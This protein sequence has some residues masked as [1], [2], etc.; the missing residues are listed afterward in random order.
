MPTS[1]THA[2]SRSKIAGDA[3]YPDDPDGVIA[4]GFIAAGP[5]DESS[6]I[7]IMDDTVDTEIARYLDR[8]DM[9]A[10]TMSTFA[11]STVHCARCHDHKSDPIS[12]GE[13]HLLHAVFAGVK[14][15]NRHY[16]PDPAVHRRRRELLAQK[17]ALPAMTNASLLAGKVQPAC[18]W[19][20]PPA[21]PPT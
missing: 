15:A 12:Q 5:W 11:G 18:G 19:R 3:L 17:A 20:P 6:Q 16:D 4:L 2:S 14:R 7:A 10:T 9:V 21:P 13:Y 8:D 1:P